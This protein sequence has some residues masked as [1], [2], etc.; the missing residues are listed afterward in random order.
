MPGMTQ[1]RDARTRWRDRNWNALAAVIASLI[2][3]LALAVSAYT[4]R[5]QSQ[6]VR[7][8]VWPRLDL[9]RSGER[10]IL[11]SNRGTGPARVRAVRV[12]AD[13]RPVKTWKQFLVA[14]TK[15]PDSDHFGNSGISRRVIPAGEHVQV[16]SARDNEEG[17]KL[18]ADVFF[19]KA[20]RVEIL[21]CYCSVLDQCWMA[22]GGL[23][24]DSV[25]PDHEVDDCSIPE[26]ERFTQ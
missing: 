7:A 12:R 14:L 5:L 22:G 4:A 1:A 15:N 21:V 10:H 2:G 25:D 6:Q 9:S 24:S 18:F 23:A 26:S 20:S 13:G 11:V 19:S 3:L 8:Q 16:F 17:R